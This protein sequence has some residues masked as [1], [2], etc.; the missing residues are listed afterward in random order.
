MRRAF[1]SILIGGAL[2]GCTVLTGAGDFSVAGSVGGEDVAP[3]E[4]ARV[5][6][7]MPEDASIPRS[8]AP[9][10]APFDVEADAPYTGPLYRRTLTISSGATG[11]PAQ[12][13]FCT[14]FGSTI[15][16]LVGQAK[17]RADYGDLRVFRNGA[18]LPRVVE[19][20][21][22]T[23]ISVCFK[24]PSGLNPNQNAAYEI[25]YGQPSAAPPA[26]DGSIFG[27]YDGFSGASLG[28]QWIVSGVATIQS[29]S[30]R[31][32]P[33]GENAVR[34]SAGGDGVPADATLE[35]RVRITDPGSA[36]SNANG[37]FYWFGFQRDDFN[38]TDPW[39]IWIKRD[40]GSLVRA[41]HKTVG[42]ATCTTT[43]TGPSTAQSTTYRFYRITRLG[44]D[45]TFSLEEGTPYVAP[46]TPNG[47]MG[48]MIRN[49]T[50]SSDV[51]VDWV[52][53]RALVNPEPT[54]TSLGSEQNL[55]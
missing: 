24:L 9:A 28:A 39:S 30:L 16:G 49:Y 4:D 50:T 18:E 45:T 42:G 27:F 33:G 29:G 12:Y 2:G 51:L 8:D 21:N 23:T 6:T 35:M 13:T 20:A 22:A 32:A 46:A 25:R 53:A 26:V 19:Q 7:S 36:S 43:C 34:T 54:V 15:T 55:P 14:T 31:L 38:A 17:L 1:G 10:D 11:V 48:I 41:E 52:R 5:E 44:S 47:D 40:T 3:G 37:Y